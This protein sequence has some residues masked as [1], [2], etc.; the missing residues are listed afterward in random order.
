MKK[1]ENPNCRY[2]NK[3]KETV[4]HLVSGCSL[5]AI[6]KYIER[7]NRVATYIHWTLCRHYKFETP[8]QWYKHEVNQVVENNLVTM[9]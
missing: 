8:K 7:H 3:E 5:L 2:C 6:K 9:L 1:E 4:D